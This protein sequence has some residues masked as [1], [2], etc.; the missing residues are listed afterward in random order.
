[1]KHRWSLSVLES[2]GKQPA[3]NLKLR[4]KSKL[5][6]I[7]LNRNLGRGGGGGVGRL[8]ET[9]SKTQRCKFCNPVSERVLYNFLPCSTLDPS[10]TVFKTV[11]TAHKFVFSPRIS[12]KATLGSRGF[13]L[14]ESWGRNHGRRG[15]R[16]EAEL[17]RLAPSPPPPVISAPALRERETSG[18]QGKRR[19]TISAKVKLCD[20][21]GRKGVEYLRGPC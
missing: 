13:S 3:T 6:S 20:W 10:I 7:G 12:T 15:T 19:R 5:E 9:L 2:A 11:G 1:M 17:R 21:G 8:N 14:S 16:G 4:R 18:T